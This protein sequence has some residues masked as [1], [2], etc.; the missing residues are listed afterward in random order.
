[1]SPTAVAFLARRR[2]AHVDGRALDPQMAAMLA[3]DDLA[4]GFDASRDTPRVARVRLAHS[5]RVVETPPPP[6][7]DALDR[8]AP[9][10]ASSIPVR[11]YTPAGLG[12]PS[13]MVVFFHGGGWVTGSIAT[14]DS[15]CRRLAAG[16]R[17]RVA[18][19]DYRLA[20]EHRFPAAVDDALAAYRW[21]AGRAADLGADPARLAVAGDSAGGNLAAV[22]ALRARGDTP[23][24]ALQILLYPGLDMTRSRPSQRTLA[25][26]YFL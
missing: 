14:H 10:P 18:S 1:A 20:P 8:W 3:L 24:P 17:C 13:P 9:G 12:A 19:V 22:I 4:G 15:F 23:A 25:E 7:V 21:V 5:V 26:G 11:V 16:A 2:Q 6:G